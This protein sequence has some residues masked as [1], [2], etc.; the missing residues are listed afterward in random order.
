MR[1]QSKHMIKLNSFYEKIVKFL[2]FLKQK[3]SDFN[4][5]SCFRSHPIIRVKRVL[6]L[7]QFNF[8]FKLNTNKTKTKII[9]EFRDTNH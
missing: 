4:Q 3:N 5:N 8:E 2:I 1:F 9:S 6:V 7:F